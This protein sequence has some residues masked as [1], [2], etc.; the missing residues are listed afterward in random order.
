LKAKINKAYYNAG[1][2]AVNLKIV[3]F[4][5]EFMSELVSKSVQCVDLIQGRIRMVDRGLDLLISFFWHRATA[6]QSVCIL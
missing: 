4:A 3:G 2:V 1:V 6:M 5:P